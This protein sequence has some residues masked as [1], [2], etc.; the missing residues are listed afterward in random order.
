MARK[1]SF[2]NS[3]FH[4]AKTDGPGRFIP[5]FLVAYV[6][7]Y[8]I[9]TAITY[10]LAGIL[11]GSMQELQLRLASE[12]FSSD[13]FGPFLLYYAVALGLGVMFWLAFEAALLRRYVH[14]EPFKLK[15][16]GDEARL[17]VVGLIWFL[18]FMGAYLGAALLIGLLTTIGGMIDPN[19]GVILAF[20]ITLGA[21]VAWLYFSVRLS[22]AGALTIRDRQIRFPSAMHVTKGRFW[23]LL[24]SY[25]VL[26]LIIVAIYVVFAVLVFGIVFA[27]GGVDFFDPQSVSLAFASFESPVAYIA[28]AALGAVFQGMFMFAWA[29]PAAL[30]AKV[31]PRRGG[32]PDAASV[33]D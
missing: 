20:I 14:D 28:M 22:A 30:A 29:G 13:I 3:A 18:L 25:I 5:V 19:F 8:S 15:L 31:D 23:T 27:G 4:F 33:F 1:F 21:L 26:F 10:A 11:F 7:L 6:I 32:G 9:I 17:F 12:G 24:G 16:G 2:E